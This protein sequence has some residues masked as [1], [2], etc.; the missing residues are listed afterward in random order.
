MN[1]SIETITNL[2]KRLNYISNEI[3]DLDELAKKILNNDVST[4]VP[5]VSIGLEDTEPKHTKNHQP[6]IKA[7]GGGG[8][9]IEFPE[10]V[11]QHLMGAINQISGED[12]KNKTS[13]KEPFTD[14]EYISV[15]KLKPMAEIIGIILR[16]KLNEKKSIFKQ[17]A[18]HGIKINQAPT[19]A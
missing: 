4:I 9:P 10:D 3:A 12:W 8:A 2:F 6:T 11:M 17:L 18:K 13:S 15:L 16:E 19:K 14:V 7:F 1:T 5:F